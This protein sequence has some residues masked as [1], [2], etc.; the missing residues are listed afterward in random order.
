MLADIRRHAGELA[1]LAPDVILAT[2]NAAMQAIAGGN[3]APCRSCSC[4]VVD[5]VG[6]GY[7]DSMARPGGNA[8]GFI[9]FEYTSSG[10]WLGLLK[11]IAPHV[12]RVAVLRD[13]SGPAQGSA[14]SP[15]SSPWRRRLGVEAERDQRARRRRDRARPSLL[16]RARSNGGL[17]VTASALAAVHR[18]L[19][20]ALAARHKLPAVYPIDASSSPSGGLISYGPIFIDQYRRAASYVDRILKGAKPSRPAG[21][22]ADQVR[23][24]DQPQDRQGARPRQCRRRYSPAPTR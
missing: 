1:A 17:I 2:G 20:I 13:P 8:T 10:K 16:S 18:D 4:S 19:I 7:V 11:E 3:A 21:A 24:G 12:K 9:Q 5:P 6:A 14:N 23:T 22:S 15:L